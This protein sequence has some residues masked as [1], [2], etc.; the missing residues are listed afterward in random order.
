L[1]RAATLWLGLLALLAVPASGRGAGFDPGRPDTWRV[2]DPD[3]YAVVARGELVWA[4]GYWGTVLRSSDAGAS[5]SAMSTP[6][7]ATLFD[8]SFAD[9]LAGWVVG[10]GGVVLRTGDGGATWVREAVELVDEFGGSFPLETHLFGVCALSADETW[11]VGDLGIVLHRRAGRWERV[12]LPEASFGDVNVPDRIL[13]AVD[14]PDPLHGWIVGEFGTTLRTADGGAT[15][16][17]A[18]RFLGAADDLYLYD[19]SALDERRAAAVGLAGNVLVTEDGGSTWE[20]RGAETSAPL[21]AVAWGGGVGIAVGNRG[22]VFATQDAGRS[23]RAAA[24]PRLFNWLAGL[25]RASPTRLYAVGEKGLVLRS[26]DGG[27]SWAQLFGREPPPLSGV[28][29]P[30]PGRS[31]EAPESVKI[32]FPAGETEP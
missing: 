21:Y 25:A 7:R 32:P 12:V 9:D 16:L 29:V 15:W 8:V 19:V 24:R 1:I 22:E 20:P 27:A 11:A 26:D 28:S 23:W 4:V 10:E 5:W 6:T 31:R 13:N 30:D 14:F 17:G 2:P 18:R 3:L